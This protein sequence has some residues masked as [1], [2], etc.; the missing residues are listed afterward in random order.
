MRI[1]TNVKINKLRLGEFP[2]VCVY[3]SVCSQISFTKCDLVASCRVLRAFCLPIS[4]TNSFLLLILS[5]PHNKLPS[6][7]QLRKLR[8]SKVNCAKSTQL[9]SGRVLPFPLRL[10]TQEVGWLLCKAANLTFKKIHC[11]KQVTYLTVTSRKM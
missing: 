9:G 8:L 7:A 11:E 3:C 1:K 2:L 10:V 5:N 6:G 4:V